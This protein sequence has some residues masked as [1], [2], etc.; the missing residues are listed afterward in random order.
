MASTKTWA[1]LIIVLW[2]FME[3]TYEDFLLLSSGFFIYCLVEV[4][5]G[6]LAAYIGEKIKWLICD[7]YFILESPPFI[8]SH[9]WDDGTQILLLL[10]LA[11]PEMNATSYI[12]ED[13]FAA[14]NY[15]ATHGMI[16]SKLFRSFT[17]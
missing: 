13:I 7:S 5:K 15:E 17:K 3:E 6:Y 10:C 12:L 4:L 8:P 14:W 1:Q 11:N 9:P 16:I 2:I